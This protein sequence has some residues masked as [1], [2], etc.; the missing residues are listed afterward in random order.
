MVF[1]C[2]NGPAFV[3]MCH[4]LRFCAISFVIL[5]SFMASLMLSSHLFFGLPLLFP[6][7]SMFIIVLLVS[8]PSFLNMC[9]YHRSRY[10]LGK[11]VIGS[12]SASLQMSS[13]LM[14]SFSMFPNGVFHKRLVNKRDRGLVYISIII[15]TI[16]FKL[17]CRKPKP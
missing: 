7:S 14:W 3:F 16:V 15:D 1:P 5:Y 11:V 17:E 2:S 10:C 4:T 13:F 9:P 12:M 6:Y 8:S